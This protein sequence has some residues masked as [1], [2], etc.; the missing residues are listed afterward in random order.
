MGRTACTEPQ[1][2]Y[3]GALYPFPLVWCLV[4]WGGTKTDAWICCLHLELRI[5]RN[6]W[7]VST[8]LLGFTPQNPVVLALVSNMKTVCFRRF[9]GNE[10][11]LMSHAEETNACSVLYFEICQWLEFLW[12]GYV[13]RAGLSLMVGLPPDRHVGWDDI[14][15]IPDG[16]VI[17]Q[18]FI[19][20]CLIYGNRVYHEKVPI[21]V[22]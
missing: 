17:P 2:L 19:R 13:P 1:C 8:K 6:V 16:T 4:L 22:G 15:S 5:S 18:W 12:M 21:T 10:H 11:C 9:F 7:D 20:H 3:N 14:S